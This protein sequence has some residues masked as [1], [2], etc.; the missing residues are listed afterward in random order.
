MKGNINA[1]KI[2]RL[3]ICSGLTSSDKKIKCTLVGMRKMYSFRSL[4]AG[5]YADSVG[6]DGFSKH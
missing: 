6:I 1:G 3:R 5:P 4:Q 2:R